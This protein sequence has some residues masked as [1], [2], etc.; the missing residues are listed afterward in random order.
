MSAARVQPLPQPLQVL[1]DFPPAPPP[2]NQPAQQ[3]V[4]RRQ[5]QRRRPII[6][7]TRVVNTS[8][9][10][11]S[12][13]PRQIAPRS[14]AISRSSSAAFAIE[15]ARATRLQV[16][17]GFEQLVGIFR[18]SQKPLLDFFLFDC[19]SSC[20][21]Q[22]PFTTCSFASTVWHFG[23]VHAVCRFRLRD[24]RAPA[25]PEKKTTDSNGSIGSQVDISLRS[26]KLNR[27][28]CN[29]RL[30]D[31]I[32]VFVTP[33]D[34]S[35]ADRRV[36]AGKPNASHPWGHQVK[37]HMRLYGQ[38]RHQSYNSACGPICIVPEGYGSISST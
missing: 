24:S 38:Q 4:F 5:D 29:T 37:S 13:R 22:H 20:R 34:G 31:S 15:R 2:R 35:P 11:P 27:N 7:S 12:I 23:T 25:S 10:A 19:V 8:I 30:N 36:S 3:R 33:A 28:R 26:R 16:G 17:P 32:F 6:V 1:F 14:P 21:Q 18:D 9:D